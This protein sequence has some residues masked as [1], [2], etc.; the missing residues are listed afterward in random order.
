VDTFFNP[1][2]IALVGAT[3]NRLKGGNAILQNLIKGFKKNIHPVNPG[4][5]EI[6]GIPCYPSLAEVPDPVDLGALTKKAREKGKP[7]FCWLIG[8]EAAAKAYQMLFNIF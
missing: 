6:M 3:P 2:G 1:K 5:N 7:V 8:E 4:Y